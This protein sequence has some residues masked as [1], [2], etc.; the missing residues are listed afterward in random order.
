MPGPSAPAPGTAGLHVLDCGHFDAG[1]CRSCA[2]LGRAYDDQLAGKQAVTRELV[3][4]P[5]L[6]WL[7]PVVSRP[8]GFRNKA[9][10]VVAGSVD[11]PTL[12]ILDPVGGG[13]DLRD[14]ALHTPG[15]V[16][17]LPVL[18]AL[19]TRAGLTP[20]DVTSSAP[21]TQRGELKHVLVTEAPSGRLMVRLVVRST[22]TEARVRKH[23][24]WLTA[25][26]PPLRVVTLN[27]Q[28]EHRAVLE[29]DREIVLTEADTLPMQVNGLTLHLRPRSFFQTNTEVAAALYRQARDW[30][31]D[32]APRR[33][34]D[35]Y[36]GVGG[37]ALHLA[38]AGRTVTGIEI[39]A[40][41]IASAERSRDEAALPGEL[42]FVVGDAT[43]PEHA[44]LIDEADLV[45][46][47][48]P[49]RG[50]GPELS[51]RI[52]ESG[53]PHVLYSS[54][55]PQTLARDL[56]DL[57]SYAPVRAQVLDMFPQTPHSEVLVLLR[58]QG[59]WPGQYG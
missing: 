33:V 49:R 13:I 36:C 57:A 45:V 19:V 32:L 7:P 14:C 43:A 59:A 26:L 3:D 24:P 55:N 6:R 23:L 4:R 25:E 12:G 29:G 56:A 35:L 1:R 20:Y 28:P 44:A 18:G 52:E 21:V 54:C 34:V 50:L 47:N 40:D 42:R 46:V 15:I 39:S 11:T 27:V 58:R 16:A 10:M 38:A 17:A 22:A 48:P 5:G 2:W 31:A 37:F 30:V 41:A 9:K 8:E 53:P 51:R